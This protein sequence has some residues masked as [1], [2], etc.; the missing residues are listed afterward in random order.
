[1]D[2]QRKITKIKWIFFV[3]TRSVDKKT[4]K[5]LKKYICLRCSNPYHIQMKTEFQT[6]YFNGIRIG[7]IGVLAEY[8][9]VVYVRR[10]ITIFITLQQMIGF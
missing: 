6:F 3:H 2:A 9:I 1:M 5:P 8:L 7:A 10:C 4:S